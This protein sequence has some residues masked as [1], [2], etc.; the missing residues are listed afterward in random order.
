MG[1]TFIYESSVLWRFPFDYF[2]RFFD[3]FHSNLTS[4]SLFL[5]PVKH[6]ITPRIALLY[7]G[8]LLFGKPSLEITACCNAGGPNILEKKE[9]AIYEKIPNHKL[10]LILSNHNYRYHE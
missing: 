2:V 7:K 5:I 1:S 9:F 6:V 4:S 8:R 10:H 3:K